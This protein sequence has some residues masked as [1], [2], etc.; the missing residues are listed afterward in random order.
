MGEV[1]LIEE[2]NSN[3][4]IARDEEID[5]LLLYQMMWMRLVH[6]RSIES[7]VVKGMV[8]K[9]RTVARVGS[10]AKVIAVRCKTDEGSRANGIVGRYHPAE[11]VPRLT[12]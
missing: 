1:R 3:L 4:S 11:G 9:R 2:M 10:L 5:H 8:E 7:A 6:R 12:T